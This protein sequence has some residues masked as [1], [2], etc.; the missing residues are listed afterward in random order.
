MA[1]QTRS[2]TFQEN[3]VGRPGPFRGTGSG[4]CFT[5]FFFFTE[6]AFFL[7]V[8][9]FDFMSIANHISQGGGN[10]NPPNQ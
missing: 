5:A 9:F 6:D 1:E 3:F 8:V 2:A 4:R 7:V 10:K